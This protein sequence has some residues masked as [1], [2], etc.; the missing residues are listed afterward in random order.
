M[1]HG[2][3]ASKIGRAIKKQLHNLK[4]DQVEMRSFIEKIRLQKGAMF[5]EEGGQ[6]FRHEPDMSFR[7]QNALWPGIVIE[8]AYSQKRKSLVKLANNYI[9]NSDGGIGVFVGIELIYAESKEAGISTWRL[10]LTPGKD[11]EPAVAEVFQELNNELFRDA[12]G[13]PISYSPGLKLPLNDFALQSMSEGLPECSVI[14]DAEKLCT[15]LSKAE[16]EEEK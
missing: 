14:V 11:G 3:F 6:K 10:K 9:L 12:E 1:L 4:K 2:T 13:N 5:F 15:K 16:A 7:H 8:V